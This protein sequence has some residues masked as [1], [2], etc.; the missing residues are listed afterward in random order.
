[1][2][3]DDAMDSFIQ[4][5]L[6]EK[7]LSKQTVANYRQDL[8][9]FKEHIKYKNDVKELDNEDVSSLIQSMSQFGNATSTIIRRITTI[10]CFYIFL[11]KEGLILNSSSEIIL[12][13]NQKRLPNVLTIDEIEALLNQPDLN[14]VDGIR[15]KAMLEVMYASGLRVS[16]LLTLERGNLNLEQGLIKIKGKGSK[17]RIAPLGDYARDAILFYLNEARYKNKGKNNK[18]LFLNKN[19]EPLSRQYFWKK[20]KDYAL[21]AGI[22]SCITPHTLR[23]SFATHLLE[24]GA[25]LRAVQE[26]LGH[27]NIATTQIYTHVSSKRILSAYDL[28]MNDEK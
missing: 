20:L 19:G 12:P 14:K 28:Y 22:T 8:F 18:I 5:C 2:L 24:N 15:D 1:M 23:H 16:E 26:M 27:S 4:Y 10:K 9:T 7:G 13:K 21:K 6:V 3:I 25:E 11:Q 17:E